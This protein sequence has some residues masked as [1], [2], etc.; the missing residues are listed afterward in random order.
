MQVQSQPELQNEMSLVLLRVKSQ[1]GGHLTGQTQSLLNLYLLLAGFCK[2]MGGLKCY[3]AQHGPDLSSISY[4]LGS[5]VRGTNCF[6]R[7]RNSQPHQAS[8]VP[9]LPQ[10]QPME[11]LPE[12]SVPHPVPS[13]VRVTSSPL[14]IDGLCTS[15]VSRT[16]PSVESAPVI[17]CLLNTC[18]TGIGR[19]SGSSVIW[20]RGVSGQ[21][22]GVTEGWGLTE[23]A[24]FCSAL[25]H[26]HP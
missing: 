5:Q 1:I 3:I 8:T 25:F 4:V 9:T 13:W 22:E 23:E 24:E 15:L 19:G 20:Q 26:D 2:N 16:G 17:D 11:F 18:I 10:P 6:C 7:S 12:P 21:E 14:P